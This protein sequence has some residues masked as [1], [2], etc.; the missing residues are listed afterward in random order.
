M[1][2]INIDWGGVTVILSEAETKTLENAESLVTAVAGM[3]GAAAG[4][5][6][7]T[8]PLLAPVAVVV[9]K[10]IAVVVPYINLNKAIMTNLDQGYGVNLYVPWAAIWFDQYWVIIPI[11]NSPPPPSQLPQPASL[12]GGIVGNPAAI[13]NNDGRLEVF[14]IGSDGEL[15][16]IWQT[17]PGG[18][19]GAAGPI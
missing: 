12:G 16:H 18:A 5:A 8:I 15:N 3:L 10:L 14:A 7:V 6:V 4:V 9:A 1:A 19:P 11:P 2:S 17:S 13:M